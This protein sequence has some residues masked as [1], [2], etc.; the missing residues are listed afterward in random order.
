LP[1][2]LEGFCAG[3]TAAPTNKAKG[4]A[5]SVLGALLSARAA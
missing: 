5:S 1:G 3:G 2:V 4:E